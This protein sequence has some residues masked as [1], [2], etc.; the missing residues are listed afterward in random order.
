MTPITLDTDLISI[1]EV[2]RA[3]GF[4]KSYIYQ[5]IKDGDFPRPKKLGASSRWV[6]GDV[7]VWK[8]QFD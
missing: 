6:R 3:T 8:K 2:E 7:E 4:K 5:K 1:K